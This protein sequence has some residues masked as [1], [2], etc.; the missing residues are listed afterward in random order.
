MNY[1]TL[2]A[3]GQNNAQKAVNT[4]SFNSGGHQKVLLACKLFPI[5]S[6]RHGSCCGF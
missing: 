2:Q 1:L 6:G 5:L 3:Y 4:T